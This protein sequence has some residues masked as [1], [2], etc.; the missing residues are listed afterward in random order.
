MYGVDQIGPLRFVRED[1]ARLPL[2]DAGEKFWDEIVHLPWDE[3]KERIAALV[4]APLNVISAT[5]SEAFE[6]NGVKLLFFG[7]W[8]TLPV[9][10]AL[11]AWAVVRWIARSYQ[12]GRASDQMLTVDV[13]MLIFALWIFL[14]L[15]SAFGWVAAAF[16][17]V[18]FAAYKKLA[19]W[20]LKQRSRSG[21]PG[22]PR[23][24]LLLRVF[25]FD[26]RTQGLLD[27]LSR[28][29]RHLGPIRL[30]GGP[31]LASTTIEPHEFFEFLNGRLSRAFIKSEEDLEERLRESR[32]TPDLDGLFR[33]EDFFCHD[34]TWRMTVSRIAREADAVLMDLRGFTPTNRGCVHEIEQLLAL[35]PLRRIAL[36]VDNT[37][38]FSLLEHTVQHA[39]SV[40]PARS[41]NAASGVHRLR[42]LQAS[43]STR[44]TLGTLLGLL[45]AQF[46][47]EAHTR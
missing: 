7:I 28:T 26:K 14:V 24:L 9:L 37:T 39:W 40:M 8:L 21:L 34:D 13:L 27:Q 12:T 20:Q 45:C 11:A 35:V 31:D 41:P 46:E 17:P 23:T 33:I 42:I 32:T 2:V 3:A 47:G 25:G 36:L 15:F 6:K 38:D 22:P 29:W 1:L 10:G 44:N 4:N 18:S 5:N 16:A 19:L 30:I 43:S